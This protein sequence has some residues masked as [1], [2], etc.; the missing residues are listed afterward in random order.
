MAQTPF[1]IVPSLIA[2]AVAYPQGEC[3]AD[4]VLPRVPVA[5]QAF[6]YLKH[7]LGDAFKTPDTLVG[8][9]SAPNQ[10]DWG[11]TEL[12]AVVQDHGLDT[13]VP[14]SDILAYS[15]AQAAGPGFVSPWHPPAQEL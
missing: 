6:R 10:L 11:S 2:I 5:T 15:Q 14:N 3:I 12:S 9:K 8:R 1:V 4:R 7:S 13:A